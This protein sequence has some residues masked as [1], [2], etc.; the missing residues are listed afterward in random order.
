MPPL[1]KISKS[2]RFE[3]WLQFVQAIMFR[4]ECRFVVKRALNTKLFHILTESIIFGNLENREFFSEV[5]T[6]LS[7]IQPGA[8]K[9]VL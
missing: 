5:K 8:V 3:C 7:Y 9:L 4:C 2:N 1:Q 6:V